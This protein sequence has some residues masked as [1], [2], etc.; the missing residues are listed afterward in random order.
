MDTILYSGK[1]YAFG[2]QLKYDDGKFQKLHQICFIND[3]IFVK[4]WLNA[5]TA[6]DAPPVDDLM[7]W[8]SL[9]MYEKYEPGVARADLL[10]FSRHLW[11]LT[12]EAVTF[13]VFSKK[14]S[15]PE[16]K[17]ISASL[18]KYKPNEKSFPTGLS[19]FPVLNHATKLHPLVGPKAWLIFHLFKQYGAWLRF[20]L[21][22][23]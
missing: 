3:L 12:E 4:V 6:A 9:N 8:K 23:A 11:Y 2:K 19:V 20:R 7:L 13:S 16:T 1:M 10:T 18:M 5:Q 17:E 15:D 21:N 14:V 22:Q